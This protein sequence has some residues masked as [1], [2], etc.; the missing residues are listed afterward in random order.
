M[1]RK[2]FY[3]LIGLIALFFSCTQQEFESDLPEPQN[4]IFNVQDEN[5]VNIDEIENIANNN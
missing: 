4:K 3:L 5:F 1:N 2:P